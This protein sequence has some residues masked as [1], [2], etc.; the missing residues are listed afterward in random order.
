MFYTWPHAQT[1]RATSPYVRTLRPVHTNPF[2]FENAIFSLR[3]RLPSS[4]IRWKLSPKTQIFENALQRGIFCKRPFGVSFQKQWRI[5]I[6]S[7]EIKWHGKYACMLS[8]ICIFSV[9]V[10]MGENN[11]KMLHVDANVLKT[12]KKVAF[13]NENEYVWTGPKLYCIVLY[14]ILF[15]WAVRFNE[16]STFFQLFCLKGQNKEPDLTIDF[17]NKA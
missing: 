8:S 17:L 11:L 4:R 12:E 9:F 6:G 14:C 16:R 7:K 3:M 5:S 10:W 13:S 2:S 15:C 1:S